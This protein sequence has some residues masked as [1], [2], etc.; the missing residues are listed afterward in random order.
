MVVAVAVV[1]QEGRKEGRKE[2]KRKRLDRYPIYATI[3]YLPM[4]VCI[5]HLFAR[6]VA[7]GSAVG[8]HCL[9]LALD[10]E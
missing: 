5:C 10:D 2:C 6:S 1:V 8:Q 9:L 7:V 3:P 4:Y